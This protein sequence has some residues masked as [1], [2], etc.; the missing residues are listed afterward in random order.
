MGTPGEA[1]ILG[2]AELAPQHHIIAIHPLGAT[3]WGA[4]EVGVGTMTG[5]ALS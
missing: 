2:D 5:K 1:Q 4:Q 3:P